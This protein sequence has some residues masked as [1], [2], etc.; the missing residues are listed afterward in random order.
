MHHV[1][2][3]LVASWIALSDIVSPLSLSTSWP[4]NGF[5]D[6]TCFK[7]AVA[8]Q[9]VGR[10]CGMTLQVAAT[11]QIAMHSIAERYRDDD[12]LRCMQRTNTT[13][14]SL[15]CFPSHPPPRPP[16]SHPLV[17]SSRSIVYRHGVCY[18]SVFL[19]RCTRGFGSS[20]HPLKFGLE[21]A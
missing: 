20:I 15:R 6:G 18:Y 16:P 10:A 2:V 4:L 12:A 7:F 17:C 19:H 5:T 3:C 1:C 9:L 14:Y 11:V 8:S 21:V 13:Y